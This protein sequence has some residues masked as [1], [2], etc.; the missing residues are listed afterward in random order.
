MDVRSFRGANIDS[1]HYLVLSRVRSRIS[2]MRKDKGVRIN[3]RFNS[4]RLKDPDIASLYI[5]K[6][7]ECLKSPEL[8]PNTPSTVEESW[9][10][11]SFKIKETA[12]QILGR[13]DNRSNNQDDWFDDDCRAVTDEKT[14]N[15]ETCIVENLRGQP[16]RNIGRPGKLKRSYIERRKETVSTIRWKSWSTLEQG[17]ISDYSMEK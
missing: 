13:Q 6:L 1:D 16:E 12:D 7:D 15:T 14:G 10:Q 8:E 2:N 5:N 3:K 11:L 4:D 9:A 17:M